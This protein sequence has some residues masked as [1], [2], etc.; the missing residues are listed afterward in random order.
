[1]T[2][3]AV[4]VEQTSG[5]RVNIALYRLGRP[6]ARL[7]AH[8]RDVLVLQRAAWNGITWFVAITS[9]NKKESVDD[10]RVG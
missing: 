5:Q 10:W 2:A 9:A 1:M 6:V 7:V 8:L 3:N 4:V